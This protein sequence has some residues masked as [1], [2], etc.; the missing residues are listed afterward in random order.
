MLERNQFPPLSVDSTTFFPDFYQH[1]TKI[2]ALAGR[3][4]KGL[5]HKLLSM[6]LPS[7]R[8]G[9]QTLSLRV[10]VALRQLGV[11]HTCVHTHVYHKMR[12]SHMYIA[13]M[14]KLYRPKK[15]YLCK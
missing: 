2:I 3:E 5:A 6:L 9:S 12:G 13:T 7:L 11:E 15:R 10:Y 8:K 4:R 1:V 14:T